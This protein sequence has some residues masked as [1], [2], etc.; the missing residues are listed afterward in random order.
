MCPQR[1]PSRKWCRRQLP[2]APIPLPRPRRR[3]SRF[4]RP[5]PR[6]P[7]PRP[8][9]RRRSRS[10]RLRPRWWCGADAISR[11]PSLMPTAGG[12]SM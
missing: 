10:D 8:R 1:S 12:R 7:R 5:W 11:R 3:R 9:P 2:R 4:N 6:R